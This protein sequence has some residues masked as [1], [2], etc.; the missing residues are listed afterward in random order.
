ML[1]FIEAHRGR[2]KPSE[3]TAGLFS[4]DF[5]DIFQF[6][7][8]SDKDNL[9]A[10]YLRQR[11]SNEIAVG[12][13]HARTNSYS[14]RGS[15]FSL[16]PACPARTCSENVRVRGRKTL[17]ALVGSELN[18]TFARPQMDSSIGIQRFVRVQDRK[19]D[20]KVHFRVLLSH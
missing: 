3:N 14:G 10:H 18:S 19:L 11:Y 1:T 13:S 5:S 20:L 4:V 16:L 7:G 8:K 2:P 6:S 9:A 17:S 15:L 12:V